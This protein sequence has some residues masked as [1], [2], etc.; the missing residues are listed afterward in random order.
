MRALLRNTAL[1]NCG[2]TPSA[3]LCSDL[4][5]DKNDKMLAQS[6]TLLGLAHDAGNLLSALSLYS[7]LL[8]L[9]GVLSEEYRDYAAE[10][11]ILSDRSYSLIDR[12]VNHAH[13]DYSAKQGVV[14]PEVVDRCVGLLGKMVGRKIQTHYGTRG[15]HPVCVPEEAIERILVNLVKNAAEAT[16]KDGLLSIRIDGR[17]NGQTCRRE[18]KQPRVVMTVSDNG[19]GMNRATLLKLQQ[20]R[21]RASNGRRGVGVHVV[22]ELVAMSGGMF[23]IVSRPGVGTDVSIEWHAQSNALPVEQSEILVA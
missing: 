17:A 1:E 8:A 23:S 15:F 6:S 16:S 4:G 20:S 12:L 22:R 18:G 21:F 7:D 19:C 2:K 11:R 10:I 13:Y 3:T 5:I 9:P 14:L